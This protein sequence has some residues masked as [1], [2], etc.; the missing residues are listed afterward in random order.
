MLGDLGQAPAT[1]R[2]AAM[3]GEHVLRAARALGDGLIDLSPSH[4]V[5]IADVHAPLPTAQSQNRLVLR[6]FKES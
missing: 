1:A 5:A 6:S 2:L 4:A 3:M